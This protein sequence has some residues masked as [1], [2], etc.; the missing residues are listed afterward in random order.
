MGFWASSAA[1]PEARIVIREEEDALKVPAGALF[2]HGDGWAVFVVDDGRAR[3]QAVTV[4][5]RN[6]ES[7][8]IVE[9]LRAGAPVVLHPPDTLEDGA[10]IR[11]RS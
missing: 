9:G 2:R 8:R 7:T 6:D 3:L 10:R 4:G 5:E 11:I 1:V